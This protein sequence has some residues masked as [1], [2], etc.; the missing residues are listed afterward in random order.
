VKY[1]DFI[2]ILVK[3]G[4]VLDRT[5]GSHHQ[6]KGTIGG[7][8]R[9]VTVGGHGNEDIRPHNLASM[10]RQSGLPKNLFR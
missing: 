4:F 1:R 7:L 9:L 5:R 6:Y 3:N 2:D 8:I 10:I